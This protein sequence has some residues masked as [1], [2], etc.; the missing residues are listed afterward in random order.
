LPLSKRVDAAGTVDA[1]VAAPAAGAAVAAVVAVSAVA[2][3]AVVAAVV[4]AVA[5]AVDALAAFDF[6]LRPLVVSDVELLVVTTPP[7]A[8]LP[9]LLRPASSV[10]FGATLELFF[11]RRD[12]NFGVVDIDGEGVAS[13]VVVDVGVAAVAVAVADVAVV[14]A[15]VVDPALSAIGERLSLSPLPLPPR[16]RRRTTEPVSFSRRVLSTVF[17][18]VVSTDIDDS[19]LRSFSVVPV[20]FGDCL[21]APGS[22]FTNKSAGIVRSLPLPTL[23]IP[24]PP[25]PLR[26]SLNPRLE[27]PPLFLR[28]SLPP[29]PI[30]LPL[31][32]R[33]SLP[34][35]TPPTPPPPL[36]M[37]WR[38]IV[39]A[40]FPIEPAVEFAA[41]FEGA[42]WSVAHSPDNDKGCT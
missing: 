21:F 35:P 32:L 14:V 7:S 29:P 38:A 20:E 1:V 41:A 19:S 6:F 42:A 2:A 16:A 40:P 30:L 13:V 10:A 34:P 26:L 11:D 9:L 5:D 37:P 33:L 28:P 18:A 3:G 27:P 24:P 12:F 23:E 22:V 39:A 31:P 17:L 36:P 8:P 15:T 4:A 25:L